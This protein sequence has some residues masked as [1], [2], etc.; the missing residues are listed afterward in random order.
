MS[1][2]SGIVARLS[3]PRLPHDC[4]NSLKSS[5]AAELGFIS[6][7]VKLYRAEVVQGC[8]S[9]DTRYFSNVGH[10]TVRRFGLQS[11]A[12]GPS[13]VSYIV[14]GPSKCFIAWAEPNFR[15]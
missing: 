7:P 8:S 5:P 11:G 10:E 4:R 15:D 13:L 6:E 2:I 3:P 9:L 1:L 12:H 14:S